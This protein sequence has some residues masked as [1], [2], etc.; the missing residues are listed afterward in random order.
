MLFDGF[1]THWQR[2]S[3]LDEMSAADWDLKHVSNEIALKAVES[4]LELSKSNKVLNFNL[5]NLKAHESIAK[6]IR[7]R[8]AKRN[9]LRFFL[10]LAKSVEEFGRTIKRNYR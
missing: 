6:N 2:K 3:Q 1:K 4:H 8:L 5:N 9:F 10:L 7:L